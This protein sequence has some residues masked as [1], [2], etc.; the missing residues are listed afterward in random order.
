MQHLRQVSIALSQLHDSA[1]V[2]AATDGLK[3]NDEDARIDKLGLVEVEMC[4]EKIL[5]ETSDA[6]GS[7]LSSVAEPA[8]KDLG[9]VSEKALK[10]KALSHT[11][12]YLASVSWFLQWLIDT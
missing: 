8:N 12:G 5:G 9:I 4:H 7:P 1:N 10:G 3:F 6:S 11:V 2:L